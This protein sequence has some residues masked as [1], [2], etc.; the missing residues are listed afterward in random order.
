[1]IPR[2]LQIGVAVLLVAVLVMAFYLRRMRRETESRA[3]D[4]RPVTAPVAGPKEQLNLYVAYD[5]PG[6]LHPQAARIALPAG[7]Q[8]RAQELLRALLQVYLDKTT[9]HAL[10]AGADIRDVYMVDPGLAVIDLNPAFANGHRSGVL[11]EEL[12]VA[13]L[14]QTLT[15]NVPG[16]SRVK[17]LVDGKE[18]ET[19]AGHADLTQFFDTAA[20]NRTSQQLASGPQ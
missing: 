16:I 1:L 8:Q 5:D 10:P 4:T 11:I 12:T 19:L 7:R 17:I 2:H 6:V 13:S 3:A 9:P 15:A 20:M 18:R 14:V